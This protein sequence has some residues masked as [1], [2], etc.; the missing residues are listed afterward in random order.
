MASRNREKRT[1]CL[2]GPKSKPKIRPYPK[3]AQGD[4]GT[5]LPATKQSHNNY[6]LSQG[7]VVVDCIRAVLEVPPGKTQPRAPS[8]R[9]PEVEG[10]DPS[11]VGG[12]GEHIGQNEI[13]DREGPRHNGHPPKGTRGFRYSIR[14]AKARPSNT[15]FKRLGGMAPTPR[16]SSPSGERR[17]LERSREEN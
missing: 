17:A 2:P 1:F 15:A 4:S 8:Q 16:R 11:A 14:E 7:K 9:I 12:G 6:P 5:L 10:R 13:G 3:R